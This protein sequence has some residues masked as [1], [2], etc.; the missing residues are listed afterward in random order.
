MGTGENL[1]K[2]RKR[3]S[4]IVRRARSLESEITDSFVTFVLFVVKNISARWIACLLFFPALVFAQGLERITEGAKK[5]GKV[6]VGIT[7][8]WQEGGKPAAKRMV[9]VFQARYPF[10]K[11]DYER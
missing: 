3:S 6:K 1:R 5:E 8:R 11:V 10:V 7:V 2:T 9:E 4:L